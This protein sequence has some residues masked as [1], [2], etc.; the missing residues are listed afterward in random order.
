MNDRKA[1]CIQLRVQERLSINEIQERTGVAKGTLSD[2]LRKHPLTR[3]E[4]REKIARGCSKAAQE[5][6]IQIRGE[7]SKYYQMVIGRTLSRLQK[8]KIAESAV[9]FRLC[10]HGYSAFGSVFDGDRTDWLVEIPET[11]M[12]KKVQ[13]KTTMSNSTG[14]P[15]IPLTRCAGHNKSTRYLEGEF[16]VIVG[17][18]LFADTA[19]VFIWD[20]VKNFKKS[21]TIREDAKERWDKLLN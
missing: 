11:G 14:L 20:E 3:E 4:K 12:V 10:L 13:V 9:L 2:W 16:D 18:D 7:S 15:S 21:V 8:A 5:R 19:Y 6:H 1:M 17:Y